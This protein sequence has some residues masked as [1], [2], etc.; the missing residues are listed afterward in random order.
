[1]QSMIGTSLGIG[2]AAR[3]YRAA[4]GWSSYGPRDAGASPWERAHGASPEF[5]ADAECAASRRS[6]L[7]DLPGADGRLRRARG[8]GAGTRLPTGRLGAGAHRRQLL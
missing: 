6:R 3:A 4:R 7:D 2:M 5:P 1:M 8:L